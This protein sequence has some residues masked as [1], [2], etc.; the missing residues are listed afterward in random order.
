MESQA[1]PSVPTA[2]HG[3]TA[4]KY[5]EADFVLVTERP[6]DEV[7]KGTGP[8]TVSV[9]K[10]RSGDPGPAFA[11]DVTEGQQGCLVRATVGVKALSSAAQLVYRAL[12]D[13]PALVADLSARLGKSKDTVKQA[14]A[15]LRAAELVDGEGTPGRAYTYCRTDLPTREPLYESR[16]GQGGDLPPI[17][18][19]W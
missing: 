8:A 6:R 18:D 10:R 17:P 14:I 15:E 13:G 1:A 5:N 7:G 3:G 16:V 2:A 12:G 4:Q 11:M 9:S 19:P